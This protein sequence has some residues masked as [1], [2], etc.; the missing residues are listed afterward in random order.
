M[1]ELTARE[2]DVMQ[3]IA[4]GKTN[5]EIADDLVISESTV[6]T[7]VSNILAKL[8]LK[9]RTQI[10]IYALKHGLLNDEN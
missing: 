2:Q 8:H 9:D 10:A 7:H 4:D 1:D 3:L 6:K 5:Q